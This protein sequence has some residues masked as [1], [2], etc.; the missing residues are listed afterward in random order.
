M[1]HVQLLV[2][3]M[4]KRNTFQNDIMGLSVPKIRILNAGGKLA[5]LWPKNR[6]LDEKGILVN[7]RYNA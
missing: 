4:F 1:K 7:F 3:K 5:A 2:R 6:K